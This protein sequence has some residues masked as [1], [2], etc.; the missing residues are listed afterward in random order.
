MAHQVVSEEQLPVI[1]S[2]KNVPVDLAKD[3]RIRLDH[4]SERRA[5][6]I[7]YGERIYV[8]VQSDSAT[9]AKGVADHIPEYQAAACEQAAYGVAGFIFFEPQTDRGPFGKG[10]HLECH[11]PVAKIG[12]YDPGFI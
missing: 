1:I 4:R 7:I 6:T 2:F 8:S 5:I 3:I 9:F 11:D 12:Q 10:G